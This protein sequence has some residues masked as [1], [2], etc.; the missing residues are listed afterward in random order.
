M[1]KTLTFFF[2]L[3]LTHTVFSQEAQKIGTSS[4]VSSGKVSIAED[5]ITSVW[6]KPDM[7]GAE[8][9]ETE[10]ALLPIQIR[11]IAEHSIDNS[12]ITVYVNE[13]PYKRKN[14]SKE[15][16]FQTVPLVGKTGNYTFSKTIQLE[17]DANMIHSIQVGI[18]NKKGKEIYV[19]YPIKVRYI[20]PKVNLHILAIGA[21]PTMSP[22]QFSGKDAEDF[23]EKFKMQPELFKSIH[24]YVLTGSK[25]T[26]TNIKIEIDRLKHLYRLGDIKPQDVLMI[27]ISSHGFLNEYQDFR[28]QCTDF[29]P[30]SPDNTS[31]S[32]KEHILNALRE[33]TCK[34]IIF[35]DAC[36]SGGVDTEKL[37]ASKAGVQDIGKA[38]QQIIDTQSG[39]TTIA[40]S[41]ANEKSYEDEAWQHGAFTK[42]ILDGLS[43]KADKD[44]DGVI[45]LEEL[46]QYL[47]KAVPEMVLEVKAAKLNGEQ[48]AQNPVM[49]KKEL[50][51]IPIFIY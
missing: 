30:V 20:I 34:K 18:K 1:Q 47:E 19:D 35:L 29:T 26:T 12:D 2:A 31:L 50:K 45:R 11:I 9:L 42:G 7:E 51:N 21:N 32:Y 24:P 37:L 49:S 44:V 3:L 33:I 40:S 27:F 43:G 38:L 13:K 10:N 28:F 23:A 6:T 5:K 41:R 48:V 4:S 25:A 46:F 17:K 15:D 14:G 39:V 36:H 22:L 8:V 16:D